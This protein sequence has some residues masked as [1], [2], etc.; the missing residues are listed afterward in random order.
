[1]LID[2]HRCRL[3]V[4]DVQ[5]RLLPAIADSQSVLDQILWLVRL[6][7]RLGVPISASEQYPQGLGTTHADLL[8]ELASQ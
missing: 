5:T 2:A 6:A 1:M 8:K 7:K 3:L 4:I